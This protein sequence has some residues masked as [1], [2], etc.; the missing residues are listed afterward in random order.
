VFYKKK[1][2]QKWD[3]YNGIVAILTRP[4]PEDSVAVVVRDNY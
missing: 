3:S 4:I 1:N 2:I